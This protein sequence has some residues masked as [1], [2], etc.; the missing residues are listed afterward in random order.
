MSFVT[1]EK[2][3]SLDWFK[4]YS[5]ILLGTFI[6]SAGFVFFI[7]P[8]KMAPGGVY[9]VAI[10]LHHMLGLPIGM[11]GLALDIPLTLIGIKILGPRFGIKTVVGFVS[12]SLWITLLENLWGYEALVD[13]APLLSSIYGGALIGV[14]LGMVFKAKAT[15]GGTDIIAMIVSKYT[16]LPVGQALIIIDSVI[17]LGGLVAFGD[18]MIP[19]LSWLVIFLTGKIIDAMVE[20]VGYE[21]SVMIISEKHELIRDK[22]IND[23]RRGGTYL[24]GTGMYQGAEKKIIMTV[25]TRRELVLLKHFIGSIDNKAF[26]MVSDANEIMGDGFKSLNDD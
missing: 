10:I 26:I 9:G 1:K 6:M 14:G 12:T 17:V 7:S 22:I 21:K 8:Y 24:N 23:M 4:V 19:L 25:V 11:V 18:W 5:L 13:N 2:L 20:G 15:S 16:K 3:F